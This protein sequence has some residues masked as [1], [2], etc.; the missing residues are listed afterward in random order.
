MPT[1]G[2]QQKG[3]RGQIGSKRQKLEIIGKWMV[4]KNLA[5]ELATSPPPSFH[6]PVTLERLLWKNL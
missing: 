5:I 6:L 2:K 3:G 1:L 4:K